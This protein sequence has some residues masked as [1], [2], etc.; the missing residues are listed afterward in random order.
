VCCLFQHHLYTE[1]ILRFQAISLTQNDY[2]FVPP[3]SSDVNEV[4]TDMHFSIAARPKQSYALL[5]DKFTA[6][7]SSQFQTL[8][9]SCLIPKLICLT[10]K[11]YVIRFNIRTY[12]NRHFLSSKFGAAKNLKP[13]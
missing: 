12:A 4:L 8:I 6:V 3:F 5:S 10:Q 2:L 1:M 7:N 9:N 13:H 11:M